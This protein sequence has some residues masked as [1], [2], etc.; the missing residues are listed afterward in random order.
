MTLQRLKD[1][2]THIRELRDGISNPMQI[3]D[4]TQAGGAEAA[5]E[6]Q[7]SPAVYITTE[8]EGDE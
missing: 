8:E 1:I 6:V 4:Q 3:W 2:M 7:N 5:V